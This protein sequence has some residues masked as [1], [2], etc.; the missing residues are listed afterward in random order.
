MKAILLI[1]T[2]FLSIASFGQDKVGHG[3][4]SEGCDSS[5]VGPLTTW[6]RPNIKPFV[7][8]GELII[9][10][11]SD[12]GVYGYYGEEPSTGALIP[13]CDSISEIVFYSSPYYSDYIGIWVAYGD[14]TSSAELKVNDVSYILSWDGNTEEWPFSGWFLNTISNPFS[15]IGDTVSIILDNFK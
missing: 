2:I 9:G 12:L 1:L 3:S 4:D 15:N 14:T 11:N 5:G 13:T 6:V 10:F 8:A 7:Y